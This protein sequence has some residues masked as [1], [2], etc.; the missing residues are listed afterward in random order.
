MTRPARG[1]S[2]NDAIP[3]QSTDRLLPIALLRAREALMVRF[4]P[5]LAV[6]G[7][8]EQQWRV[9][10]VLQES[11]P[12]DASELAV[13]ACVLAPSLTRMIKS[14]EDRCFI[15]RTRDSADGRRALL[16]IT[17]TGL[18]FIALV[19]PHT[20]AVYAEIVQR[21]GPERIEHLIDMLNELAATGPNPPS[22]GKE[23]R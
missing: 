23:R 12:L 3:L 13:R 1:H 10:R 20:Q 17:A 6:H 5:L 22:N 4:R 15:K 9:L 7:V 16:S 8:T 19:I 21:Y 18:D 2:S 14:L 11:G